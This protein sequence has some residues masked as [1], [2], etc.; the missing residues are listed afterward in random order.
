[1]V[2]N[3]DLLRASVEQLFARLA[4]GDRARVGTFGSEIEI[5]EEFT[6]DVRAL[7]AALP[8][9][10][11]PDSP[12][13]LWLA[14]DQA[15][16]TFDP[17]SEERRVVLVLSDGRDSRSVGFG[18]RSSSQIQVIDKAR[19]RDTM[20]YAI[21]MRSRGPISPGIGVGP[22]AMSSMLTADMPDPGLARVAEETGG[23]YL[24]LRANDDLGAAFAQVADELH[25]QYLLG[26][27]PP[28]RDGRVHK[29]E[30]RLVPRGLTP[31][32]R[33]DYVAPRP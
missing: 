11:A 27:V 24:E 12:T 25:R 28:E 10:I 5:S 33:R 4:A 3:L 21:G 16:D 29:V 8:R 19:E 30:V 18:R 14:I 7:R 17:A 22:G 26:F 6:D 13:P 9:S 1:M 15:L 32:A 20:I 23:G 2:G 31:R